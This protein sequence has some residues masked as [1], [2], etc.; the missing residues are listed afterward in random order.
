M[1]TIPDTDRGEGFDPATSDYLVELAGAR[2]AATAADENGDETGFDAAAKRFAAF[3]IDRLSITRS[4]LY[5]PPAA[6]NDNGPPAFPGMIDAET[7]LG[8]EFEPVRSVV[9]GIIVEGLTILGGRPKLGKS[10][11]ALGALRG[12]STGGLAF[13][14]YQCE[15]G[16]CLYLALEDNQR[17]LK[18]RL[19]VLTPM[20]IK[21]EPLDR[22]VAVTE[23]K[24]LGAGLL[25][26]I[27]AW[28]RSVEKPR[29]IVI[30]T[31]Q[32]I[33]QPRK[34]AQGSTTRWKIGWRSFS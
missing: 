2:N 33:R 10:W 4:P 21:R 20:L 30:D 27:E 26:Q 14:K 23:A 19:R 12:V 13:G 31:F 15:Q 24:R 3:S 17:R 25:E 11:L 32:R 34:S 5:A 29:L 6:S 1:T 22:L 7:L 9:P 8:M 28:R 16:D 18:D